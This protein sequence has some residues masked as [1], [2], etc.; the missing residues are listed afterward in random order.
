MI[1]RFQTLSGILILS[2]LAGCQTSQKTTTVFPVAHSSFVNDTFQLVYEVES[3]HRALPKMSR[4]VRSFR[5]QGNNEP[6]DASGEPRGNELGAWTT[7]QLSIQYPH[8]NGS[9][10]QGQV[11][12]RISRHAPDT[13]FVSPAMRTMGLAK[14]CRENQENVLAASSTKS[15]APTSGLDEVWL[16]DVSKKELDRIVADLHSGG[17]FDRQK[18]PMGD[19]LL[20]VKRG[21]VK[22]SKRWTSEPVLENL[23][24]LVYQKGELAHFITCREKAKKLRQNTDA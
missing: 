12:L 13:K 7:A 15:N 19:T 9:D 6:F 18:R 21:L 24:G 1:M 5:D 14:F 16:L 11:K 23:I 20:T 17:F 3:I 10:D 22:T 4:F 8:P 2:V